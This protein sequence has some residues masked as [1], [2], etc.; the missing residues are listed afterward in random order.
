MV[1]ST[2]TA[3]R[4]SWTEAPTSYEFQWTRCPASGGAADASNCAV[5]GG[6]T[7]LKYIP[8]TIDVGKRLRVRVTASNEDGSKTVATNASAAV[9]EAGT[10][11]ST[12]PPTISG[13]ATVGS[14]LTGNRG[15]WT[16]NDPITF[17]YSWRRCD[18]D[19]GSC[20]GITGE[21]GTNYLLKSVDLGNS[22]RF[23]VVAKDATGNECRHLR[24]DRRHPADRTAGDQR[25]RE[26]GW[27]GSDLR[28]LAAGDD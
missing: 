15:Q 14:T 2:L 7:T 18:A 10:L 6:A 25:L 5:I 8:A 13:T 21:N 23:R 19:G 26:V 9:K 3:T 11:A 4:G 28:D 16:G 20:S 22:L 17:S 24:P 1:N 27:H 12:K